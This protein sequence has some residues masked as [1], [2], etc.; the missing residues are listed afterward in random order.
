MRPTSCCNRKF[1][2]LNPQTLR[3]I[4]I[5]GASALSD[6]LEERFGT[7]AASGL[8]TVPEMSMLDC[9]I[10]SSSMDVDEYATH[11]N[12]PESRVTGNRPSD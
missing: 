2:K 11:V 1:A 12:V 4:C 6:I 8:S 7:H 5:R 10:T 3:V 9:V